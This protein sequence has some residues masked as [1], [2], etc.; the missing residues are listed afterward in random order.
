M[1]KVPFD[2]GRWELLEILKDIQGLSTATAPISCRRLDLRERSWW[3]DSRSRAARLRITI[4]GEI[5]ID[6]RT[7]L[8]AHRFADLVKDD[9]E[10]APVRVT[11]AGTAINIASYVVGGPSKAL[12]SSSR[13][14]GSARTRTSSPGRSLVSPAMGTSRLSR[15]TKLTQASPGRPARSSTVRPSA[16]EP[17]LIVS[18]CTPLGSFRSLTP[19]AQGS[20]T[21]A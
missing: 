18:R 21:I 8:T 17:A 10:I 14:L 9:L 2:L 16:G 15:T 1:R 20:G 4:I 5:R 13:R 3:R 12:I 6:I 7:Q 11:S 19:S